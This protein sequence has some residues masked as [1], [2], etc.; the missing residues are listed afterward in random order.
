MPPATVSIGSTL[1]LGE[2]WM[3]QKSPLA[4]TEIAGKYP[5]RFYDFFEWQEKQAKPVRRSLWP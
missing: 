3:R 1:G 5:Q 4:V 2:E